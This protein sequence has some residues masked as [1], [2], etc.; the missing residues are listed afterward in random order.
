MSQDGLVSHPQSASTSEP[1]RPVLVRPVHG[2][3]IAGV[4]SGL[5]AHLQLSVGMVRVA[6][7]LMALAGGAGVAGYVFLWGLVPEGDPRAIPS[8]GQG[9]VRGRA[10]PGAPSAESPTSRERT[11]GRAGWMVIGGLVVAALGVAGWQGLAIDGSFWLPVV[12]L[13]AGAVFAWSQLDSRSR[14]ESMPDDPTA[15]SWTVVRVV[16]GVA[17]AVVGLVLLTTRG[18]GLADL[19]DVVIAVLVVLVGVAFIMTPYAARLWRDLRTEQTA[20]ARATERADIA[21]H[22]HD[23]VLQTLTLIQRQSVDPHVTRLARAQERELRQWLFAGSNEAEVT[24]VRAATEAAHDVEDRHGIPID[25]VLTGDCPLDPGTTALVAALREALVNAAIHGAPPISAYLEVGPGQVE[26]FVRDHGA[27]FDLD[28]VPDD[29]QGVR[30]SIIGRMARHD[31]TAHLRF[32]DT[33]TEVGLS[34]PRHR[35][36]PAENIE[37]SRD[38]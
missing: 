15:R 8:S 23:S 29:R 1:A 19:W 20:R 38:V 11:L 5:A 26:A 13:A 12:L 21:A 18:R 3:V 7:I 31:G 32:M 25:L 9:S 24:L 34:L 37:V 17:L 33:G 30:E 27:G 2:R 36:L 16:A 35:P 14:R 4:A 28:L 10:Q 22:L 6:L